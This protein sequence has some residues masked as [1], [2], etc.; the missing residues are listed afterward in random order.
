MACIKQYL[1]RVGKS[2]IADSLTK[3]PLLWQKSGGSDILAFNQFILNFY[4]MKCFL[5]F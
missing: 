3:L 5:T 1:E 2:S 4:F